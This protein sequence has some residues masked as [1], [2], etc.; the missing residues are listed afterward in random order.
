MLASLMFK[1]TP[2]AAKPAGVLIDLLREAVKEVRVVYGEKVDGVAPASVK[3]VQAKAKNAD[4]L[5]EESIKAM[6]EA[7]DEEA[8]PRRIHFV[9][10]APATADNRLGEGSPSREA[11]TT[12]ARRAGPPRP[13]C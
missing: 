12:R 3:P 7:L 10:E 1:T 2:D 8:R 13:P 6:L 11:Q 5:Q 4:D 9:R